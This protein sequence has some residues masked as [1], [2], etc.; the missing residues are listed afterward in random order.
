MKISDLSGLST[1]FDPTTTNLHGCTIG[2][3]LP[4]DRSGCEDLFLGGDNIFPY[5]HQLE[6]SVRGITFHPH[7]VVQSNFVLAP[8]IGLL[9]K[10]D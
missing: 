2:D 6:S 5:F 7:T 10:F 3:G 1:S 9:L 8:S 4:G